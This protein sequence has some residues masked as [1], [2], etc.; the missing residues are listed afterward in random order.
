M[1]GGGELGGSVRRRMIPAPR[2]PPAPRQARR[3][4]AAPS[5]QFV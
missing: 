3:G 4:N 1:G 5:P 2:R